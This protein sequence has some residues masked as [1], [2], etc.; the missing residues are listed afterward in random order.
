MNEKKPMNFDANIIGAIRRADGC[1]FFT[2]A[3]DEINKIASATTKRN[4][5]SIETRT[6]SIADA[7]EYQLPP[8]GSYKK[9]PGRVMISC[10]IGLLIED[11]YPDL[12]PDLE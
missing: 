3:Y 7:E 10:A 2:Y 11:I 9:S 5:Q 12:L 1:E 4:G 8:R 6:F